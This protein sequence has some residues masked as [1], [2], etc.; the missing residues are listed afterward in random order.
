MK[1]LKIK[2]LLLIGVFLCNI[3]ILADQQ[4]P[5]GF[6]GIQLDMKLDE[7]LLLRKNTKLM[8]PFPLES[9][10]SKQPNTLYIEY[11]I[12]HDY[13]DYVM[14]YID[15]NRLGAVSFLGRFDV[16]ENAIK[17]KFLND[18]LDNLGKPDEYVV[19]NLGKGKKKYKSPAIIWFKDEVLIIA[20]YTST[21]SLK[22]NKN[23]SVQLKITKGKD[24]KKVLVKTFSFPDLSQQEQDYVLKEAR[25]YVE[26]WGKGK[27]GREKGQEDILE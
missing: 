18:I 23:G 16:T 8:S 25:N 14:Y 3:D 21:E 22:L 17:E 24:L 26:K 6:D 13:L 15:N 1:Q 4:M 19:V 12:S 10:V 11:T 9:E 5:T 2:N 27:M 20:A 7:L